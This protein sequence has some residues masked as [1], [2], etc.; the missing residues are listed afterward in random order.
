M[1]RGEQAGTQQPSESL[2]PTRR[3]AA[4][5]G[6]RGIA[7]LVVLIHHALMSVPR[8]ADATT[9]SENSS[10]FVWAMV[11]TPLSLAWGGFEAVL[12]FFVLSGFVLV[13]PLTRTDRRFSW[14]G[15]YPK[16]LLRLYLPVWAAVALTLIIITS[17]RREQVPGASWWV[18]LHAGTPT[19]WG[20]LNNLILLQPPDT[21]NTVLWSLRW[22][23]AFSLLLP[24][25]A[26]GALHL[27][28]PMPAGAAALAALA[29]S[30]LGSLV[31]I[32][33]LSFMPIFFIGAVMA[34]HRDA[35]AS[36]HRRV[37]RPV[38]WAAAA[39]VIIALSSSALVEAVGL[40]ARPQQAALTVQ[41]A[42][43][44][45]LV[46]LFLTWPPAI[47][48]GSSRAAVWLGTRS[49][50]LYLIHEPIVVSVA[51]VLDPSN[52]GWVPAIA[53]PISLL[54]ADLFFRAVEGP[55]HQLSQ[56]VGAAAAG[57]YD[58]RGSHASASPR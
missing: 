8:L 37:S 23:V 43:A 54:A 38:I 28:R 35:I 47:S 22:E 36:T 30:G 52:A 53:V 39:A 20:T 34:V 4:L 32:P 48:V 2:G 16:R 1:S 40:G 33:W 9:A 31:S 7:A 49:F 12:V 55:S 51:L 13:L 57:R 24:L 46:A 58:R 19:L 18:D 17:I 21:S 41:I 56:R 15:Y 29:A 45:G 10:G 25:Y 27:R 42:G 6:L 5:D 14:A 3:F 26:W 44:A 50:A 11:N